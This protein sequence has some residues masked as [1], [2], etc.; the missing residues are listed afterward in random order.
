MARKKYES[1]WP[2]GKG[3]FAVYAVVFLLLLM[4]TAP[5]TFIQASAQ[6]CEPLHYAFAPGHFFGFLLLTLLALAP[7]W[8][9][10]RWMIVFL[11]VLVAACSEPLQALVPQRVCAFSDVVQNLLG[12]AAGC[13]IRGWLAV[14][15]ASRQ[16][17]TDN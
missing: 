4:T 10:S 7:R 13:A 8:P 6:Y 3:I 15:R 17:A 16:V 9:M 5:R 1:A 14:A 12:I 11:L 2:S